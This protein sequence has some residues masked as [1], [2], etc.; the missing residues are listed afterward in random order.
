MNLLLDDWIPVKLD[1]Q[2]AKISL[3][4]LLCKKNYWEISTNRDDMELA[5]IQLLICLTQSFFTPK[6]QKDLLL[7]L[8]QPL[9]EKTF[10]Q[11][12]KTYQEYFD[13]QHAKYPFMQI[14]ELEAKI[15]VPSQKLFIGLPDGNNHTFLYKKREINH[16]CG[17]CAT[18][19]LFN[20]ATLTPSFGGGFKN[21]LRGSAPITTL[22]QGESLRETIW[23]N[24]LH[25]EFI[26]RHYSNINSLLNLPNWV[27]TVKEHEE[28]QANELGLMRGL[29]WQPA[30]VKLS[31]KQS[32]SI[33]DSC[34]MKADFVVNGFCRE[35]FTYDLNGF[36]LHPHSP[37]CS[38]IDEQNKKIVTYCSFRENA[39]TWTQLNSLVIAK[40]EETNQF[41]PALVLKQYQEMFPKS[42]LNLIIGG[43]INNQSA[44]KQR[45]YEIVSLPCFL[46]INFLLLIDIVLEIKNQLMKKV[47]IVSKSFGIN[48]FLIA[49]KEFYQD[50]E[51][52]IYQV[53]ANSNWKNFEEIKKVFIRKVNKLTIEIFDRITKPYFQV[54]R[55]KIILLIKKQLE[56]KLY[57]MGNL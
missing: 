2:I 47:Y 12:I 36:F 31:W 22:I 39:P 54:E 20:Q 25:Q 18:I 15:L 23:L 55:V 45:R 14:T 51:G 17:G 41:Q 52:I 11:K 48:L 26:Y 40:K 9:N 30:R 3:K 53:L 16:V 24:V 13:I 8:E 33:C 35:R 42:R 21:P 50:T 5:S 49:E 27:N 43:Y 6:D 28:I 38:F 32:C 44:V 7:N 10:F 19:A 37:V 57:S 56:K 4:D 34:G 29:F 46:D 1:N